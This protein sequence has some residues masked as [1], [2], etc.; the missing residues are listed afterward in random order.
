M[1]ALDGAVAQL[2]ERRVRNAKV[3]SSILLGSTKYESP[4]VISWVFLLPAPGATGLMWQGLTDFSPF[5][6][7]DFESA[8]HFAL[9]FQPARNTA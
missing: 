9:L 2:G 1:P 5:L 4:T 7:T 3:G 6:I 8:H